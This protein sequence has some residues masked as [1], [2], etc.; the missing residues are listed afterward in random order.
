MKKTTFSACIVIIS[1][2]IL[3][4]KKDYKCTYSGTYN[5]VNLSTSTPYS[6]L[7]KSQA[8]AKEKECLDNFGSW[9]KVK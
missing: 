5:G 8:E 6:G 3:S 4:C 2:S 9:S 1:I 7:T